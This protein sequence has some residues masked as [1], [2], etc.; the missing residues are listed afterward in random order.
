[1]QERRRITRTRIFAAAKAF[2]P[3]HPPAPNDC[4]A[5]NI[6]GLGARLEFLTTN[7]IPSNFDLTFDAGRT[8]RECHVIWRT[9]TEVGVAF[10][11]PQAA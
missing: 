6:S 3:Q 1:M 5:L 4:F 11:D 8:L 10:L 7:A 2:A 9:T